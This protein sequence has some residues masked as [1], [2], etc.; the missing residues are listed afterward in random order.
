M[1]GFLDYHYSY[2]YFLYYFY[3]LSLV[4][5]FANQPVVIDMPEL[6]FLDSNQLSIHKYLTDSYSN[7]Q[8]PLTPFDQFLY[9]LKAITTIVLS[10]VTVAV[11]HI[12]IQLSHRIQKINKSNSSHI[13]HGFEAHRAR[14]ISLP[15]LRSRIIS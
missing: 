5:T 3:H 8:I 1:T 6:I 7:I 4:V 11:N 2:F 15:F 12:S 9:T 13:P 14:L 10:S